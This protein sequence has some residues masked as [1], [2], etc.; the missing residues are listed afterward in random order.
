MQTEFTIGDYFTHPDHP[1]PLYVLRLYAYGLKALD[2]NQEV[3]RCTKAM[4]A[5]A[6]KL[7]L[8]S[9]LAV[10]FKDLSTLRMVSGNE[11]KYDH[12]IIGTRLQHWVGIGWVDH[13][14]ITRLLLDTQLRAV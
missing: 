6:E 11:N 10:P 1:Y 12:V 7:E 14:P 2:S 4:L 3:V 13:G 9:E 5:R 8:K